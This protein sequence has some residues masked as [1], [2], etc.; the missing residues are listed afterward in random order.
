MLSELCQSLACLGYPC[1]S[2]EIKHLLFL[3]KNQSE[4]RGLSFTHTAEMQNAP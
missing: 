1:S 3:K 4:F 2:R